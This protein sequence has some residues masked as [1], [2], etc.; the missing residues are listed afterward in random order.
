M[1]LWRVKEV[2]GG[3]ENDRK[4]RLVEGEHGDFVLD[5]EL[6]KFEM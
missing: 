1:G 2:T 6:L 5:L 3:R 4:S